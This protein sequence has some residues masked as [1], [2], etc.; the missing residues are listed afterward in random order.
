MG[1]RSRKLEAV[2]RV[3]GGPGRGSLSSHPLGILQEV[4]EA[5]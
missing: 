1:R 3:N 5:L 2:N 4:V